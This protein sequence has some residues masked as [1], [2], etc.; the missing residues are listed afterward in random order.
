[1]KNSQRLDANNN[2]TPVA[3][4]INAETIDGSSASAQSTFTGE[5][6]GLLIRIKA[7][8]ADVWIKTGINPTAT[9]EGTSILLSSGETEYIMLL[10]NEKIAVYGGKLNIAKC[11]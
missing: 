1:M 6:D 4:F 3:S 10:Q 11:Y 7:T 8:S 9:S 5:D 2:P